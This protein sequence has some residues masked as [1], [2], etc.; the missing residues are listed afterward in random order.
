MMQYIVTEYKAADKGRIEI[1]LNG[2]VNLWLYRGEAK[3]LSLAEGSELSEEQ[4]QHILHEVI[5]KRAVKRAMHLLERQ[6]RTECQLREMLL[7]SAYPSEA[8]EDAVSYVK[9][10]HYLDDERY[11]RTFIRFHQDKRSKARLKSDLMQRGVPKDMIERCMEEEFA[12]D[13]RGQIYR[14]LEKKNFCPDS[15]DRNEY[16]RIYQFLMRRGF[17]SS[18]IL[19]VMNRG[20]DG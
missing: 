10:Y 12:A 15:A 2:K 8:V 20:Y 5:G 19:A 7:Q 17:Q 6:E 3:E 16:R 9:K 1:C 11:A 14:L 18:D 13:E 4:Y